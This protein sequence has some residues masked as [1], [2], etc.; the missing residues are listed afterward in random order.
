MASVVRKTRDGLAGVLQAPVLDYTRGWIGAEKE[1][2][3]MPDADCILYLPSRT[4]VCSDR[5]VILTHA[6]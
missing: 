4:F 6:L 5:P 3:M 2:L 1:E